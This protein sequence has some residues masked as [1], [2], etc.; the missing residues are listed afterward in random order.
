MRNLFAH[1]IL[2]TKP[3]YAAKRRKTEIALF[4]FRYNPPHA[5]IIFEDFDAVIEDSKVI[6]GVLDGY[7]GTLP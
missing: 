5:Q 4:N 6:L 7:C 2:N 3:D 1:S